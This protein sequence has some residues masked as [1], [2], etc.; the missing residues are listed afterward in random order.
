MA[1]N[2]YDGKVLSSIKSDIVI[3]ETIKKILTLMFTC[4]QYLVQDP[5]HNIYAKDDE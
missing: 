3:L 1:T 2:E 4:N 5:M